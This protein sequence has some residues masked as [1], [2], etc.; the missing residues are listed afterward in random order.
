MFVIRRNKDFLLLAVARHP[1]DGR[2]TSLLLIRAD[3][4]IYTVKQEEKNAYRFK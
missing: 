1:E 2:T 4:A 3:Q